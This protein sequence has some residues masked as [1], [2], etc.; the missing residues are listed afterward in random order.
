MDSCAPA[1]APDDRGAFFHPLLRR[2][3]LLDPRSGELALLP[4]E[5]FATVHWPGAQGGYFSTTPTD[6]V[7]SPD[8]PQG[9]PSDRRSDA[10]VLANPF[11][12]RRTLDP[13]RHL[14]VVGPAKGDPGR[15]A[16]SA[17]HVGSQAP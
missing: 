11:V 17:V 12:A 1:P 16:I 14:I 3:A 7:F 6:L 5:S 4:P 9:A 8:L 2:M 10:R 15:L 13:L